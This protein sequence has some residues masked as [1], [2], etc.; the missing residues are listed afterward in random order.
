[1]ATKLLNSRETIAAYK[2]LYNL[3]SDIAQYLAKEGKKDSDSIETSKLGQ[4]QDVWKVMENLSDTH[5]REIWQLS[6]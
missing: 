4:L 2:G 1:M 5:R 3:Q 6:Y